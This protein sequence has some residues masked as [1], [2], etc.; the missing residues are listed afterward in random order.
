MAEGDDCLHEF[1]LVG[2]GYY[3]GSRPGWSFDQFFCKRCLLKVAVDG[4]G[5]KYENPDPRWFGLER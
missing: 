1:N 5:Q 3:T 4:Q 2:H